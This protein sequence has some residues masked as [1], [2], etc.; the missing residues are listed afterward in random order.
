M[1]KRTALT[2]L[3]TIGLFL[4]GNHFAVLAQT[5]DEAGEKF[6][7]GVEMVKVEN[8]EAA[9][10]A[11][12]ACI[13]I[14]DKLGDEAADLRVRATAPLPDLHYKAGFALYKEKKYSE[15][16]TRL[17]KAAAVSEQY[18]DM[19]TKDK[20]NKLVSQLYYVV[21]MG[22][23]KKEDFIKTI[24]NCDK[25]LELDPDLAKA[26]LG[27]AMAY[28]KM[29]DADA[30]RA[31]IRQAI[32]KGEAGKDEKTVAS[33][34]ELG[35][36]AFLVKGQKSLKANNF[37]EARTFLGEAASYDDGDANL[38]YLLAVTHNKLSQWDEALAE[39]QKAVTK[40]DSPD[41][42][43]AAY[44]ELGTAFENKGDA[45]NACDAYKKALVGPNGAAAKYQ[46]EQVLK[47]Q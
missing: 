19:E 6:N 26:Y 47:C 8:H 42:L 12:E 27:K 3:L 39:A 43:A 9:I 13:G 2:T 22:H 36:K 40:E 44:F 33:A 14:C 1:M 5:L 21:G 46:M 38:H 10:A 20:S 34:K 41:K 24:E 29:D 45:T 23:Y 16:I 37:T 35:Y 32:E 18:G 30:M 15:A 25:A 31:A 11:F 7:Q 28:N 17:E 4:F